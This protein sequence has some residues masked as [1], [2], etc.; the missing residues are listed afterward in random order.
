MS[1]LVAV[2]GCTIEYETDP[3]STDLSLVATISDAT[4]KASSGGNKAY[5]DKITITVSAGSIT[6]N[7]TPAGAS[8]STGTV[9]PGTIEISGTSE[10]TSSEGDAFVLQD[11]EGDAT[12]VCTFTPTSG[13]NPIPVNVK[14]TA[15]VTDAGQNVLKVT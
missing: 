7:E 9:P 11:D 12:F 6:L 4:T 10:K 13:P 5:K 3:S 15:K 2:Q 14:I 8:T 1:K